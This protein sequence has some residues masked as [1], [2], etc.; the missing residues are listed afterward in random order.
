MFNEKAATGLKL[1][2][3][4]GVMFAIAKILQ[5][6]LVMFV[7]CSIHAWEVYPKECLNLVFAVGLAGADLI[8]GAVYGRS[9]I[10]SIFDR[11]KVLGSTNQQPPTT[12]GK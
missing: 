10:D 11:L 6:F 4:F 2:V 5:Q 1:I 7:E 9:V 3:R 12:E 8:D